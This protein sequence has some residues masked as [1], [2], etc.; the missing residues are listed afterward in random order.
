MKVFFRIE[1]DTRWGENLCVVLDAAEAERLK[2]DPVLGM[3]YADGEWQL[4]IDLPAGAAFD[5]RYRVVSDMG[6]TLREEWGAPHRFVA[7][8][9][10]R[11]CVR[12]DHWSDRPAESSFHSSAFTEG[13]FARGKRAAEVA[14]AGGTLLFEVEAPEVKPDEV[15]A[16]AGEPA[17]LGGWDPE[18]AVVMSDARFPI[19]SVAVKA[20]KLAP[21]FA[22]KFIVRKAATGQVV[23]WE[24]GANRYWNLRLPE[25][26][27]CV[28]LAGERFRSSRAPWRGAGV[29]IPVFS[30][31]SEESFGVGEFYD[32]K[33]MVDWAEATGLKVI[34]IL[35][36]NDTTM[37][38]TWQDSYPYNANST[39]ALHP[40]FL[41]LEAVGRLADKKAMTKYRKLG[42]ELNAL[43]EVDYERVNHAK[44]AYLKELFA[45]Q[46]AAT[47]ASK[48]FADFFRRNEA[49]LRPYAAFCTLRDKFGTP[50]FSRWGKWSVYDGK[51]IAKLTSP[52]SEHYAEV[53]LVYFVQYHLDRQLREVRNYAHAHGVILKGDIPIGISRTSCDAWVDPDLFHMNSQAGAPPDDFSVLGQNWG[54]PTYN[55]E[56]MAEDGYAWWKARFKKMSEYFDA[57][58]IDHILGFFRIWE[59]P[60]E[61][62]HGLLGH[63]NPA[64]PFSEEEIRGY[65][66]W[67]NAARHAEPYIY[68]YM[69]DDFFGEAAEE[70]RTK[71]LQE[72]GNG[73]YVLREEVDTQRKVEQLFAGKSDDRSHRI[74][75]GLMG[76]IDEVLFVED[77]VKRGLYHPR[78]SAQFTYSYRALSDGER[79]AFDRLYN[80]FYYY[81]HDDYWRGEAMRKL[82]PLLSATRMLVCGEDLGMIPHCVPQVM[83]DLQILSL[84]VQR[85]PKDPNSEFGN[86][87]GYPYRSVST[88]STHDM[89]PVRAWWEEDR[90][91]TQRFYNSVLQEPGEAPLFCE[92]WVAGK[93]V[94]LHLA[95]PSMLVIL[96]LQDWLA[97]DG[98]LRRE[99]PQEERINV[100]AIPRYYWRYRMHLT[101]EQLLKEQAFNT[102]MRTRIEANGR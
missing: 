46:G 40:Q 95:S 30:L 64:L 45:E 68:R 7:A 97:E 55:W 8:K 96:P 92:P 34:Q 54:F 91:T 31:R 24:A 3:R 51:A 2:L 72:A 85:M 19:W 69:L 100:P 43:A 80:D 35:P 11:E 62:V 13:I 16:L 70:V 83:N 47:L 81:R 6:E 44:A 63:F 71:Y 25:A 59:I 38:G 4:L 101:L 94:D 56:R 99:V 29:A 89:S 23:E 1:Y 98:T 49:W 28:T 57:Y 61:C 75:D 60:Y 39:F 93:I 84:E 50:D 9:S 87:W 12:V 102:R 42:K 53:A 17:E 27:A 41:R 67:F 58:R 79:A 76:L 21:G 88:T 20:A 90:A 78:I 48:E 15:L 86:T 26:G 74:C 73:R 22:Y 37:T 77:P 66:L 52:K 32:L 33:K 14:A 65:G 36:I 82:P 18:R 5:Y 10:L